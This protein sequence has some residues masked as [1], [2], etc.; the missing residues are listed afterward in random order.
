MSETVTTQ[1]FA[2]V[3]TGR[4]RTSTDLRGE[5]APRVGYV[6]F[7]KSLYTEDWFD[8][9]PER[10]LANIV[11]DADDVTFWLRLQRGD[12]T[13]LWRGQD[14]WYNPDFLVR[15][16]DASQWVRSRLTQPGRRQQGPR[17]PARLRQPCPDRGKHLRDQELDATLPES[18]THPS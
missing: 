7:T 15:E 6:G 16:S 4:A 3:R 9:R 10:D 5:F 2:A 14:S 18:T 13:I 12:L 11:D 8:S 17:D 1:P